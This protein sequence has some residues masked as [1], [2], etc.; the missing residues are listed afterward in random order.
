MVYK[1]GKTTTAHDRGS[2]EDVAVYSSTKGNAV[3]TN[4]TLK[5]YN[6]HFDMKTDKWCVMFPKN[7]VWE[8]FSGEC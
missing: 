6:P 1:F 5:V 7:G 3:A 4:E 8:L 2:S